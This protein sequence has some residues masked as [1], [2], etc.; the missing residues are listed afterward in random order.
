M[1]SLDTWSPTGVF[2]SSGAQVEQFVYSVLRVPSPCLLHTLQTLFWKQLFIL[3]WV[4]SYDCIA[5]LAQKNR[6]CGG[7]PWQL[8]SVDAWHGNC[9]NTPEGGGSG[10]SS[11]QGSG[12]NKLGAI[13]LGAITVK[14][15]EIQSLLYR[16]SISI[17]N[18][19]LLC[20]PLLPTS[21]SLFHL[22]L[23]NQSLN[24]PQLCIHIGWFLPS[25]IQRSP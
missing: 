14:P 9:N 22:Y 20:K 19:L 3:T 11:M 16:H 1:L 2:P 4:F 21:C 17:H 5:G 15:S 6:R 10:L 12:G 25:C 7:S 23:I 13:P 18:S 8:P 24:F